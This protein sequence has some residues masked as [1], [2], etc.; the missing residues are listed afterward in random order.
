[1]LARVLLFD[2]D[3]AG[4]ASTANAL[5]G[6]EIELTQCCSGRQALQDLHSASYHL[7]L[8]NRA[9]DGG[10]SLLEQL[11]AAP[12]SLGRACVVLLG[13]ASSAGKS[14]PADLLPVWDQLPR[15]IPAGQ[16]RRCVSD[17][18]VTAA[19]FEGDMHL[20]LAYRDGCLLQFPEDVRKGDAALRA[21][22]APT[23][24]RLAHDLV[25]VMKTLG[26]PA[27][28]TDARA[29]QTAARNADLLEAARYWDRLR[30][31][32]CA[33]ARRA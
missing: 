8:V 30:S 10:C 17:S 26:Q 2:E 31:G 20:A 22:D 5:A 25:A 32:L 3:D 14:P 11:A 19:Y 21:S 7:L 29:V 15:Q 1:M 24:R 18:L 27:L 16:I 13:D 33:L 23:L 6:I 28:A 9:T 12:A 4:R